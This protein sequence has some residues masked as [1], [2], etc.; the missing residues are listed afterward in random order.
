MSGGE[1]FGSNEGEI[2]NI[3]LEMNELVSSISG[4]I[5]E[6]F[7]HKL[8]IK[9]DKGRDLTIGKSEEGT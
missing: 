2:S 8:I 4:K 7:F 5:G 6:G 1:N 9:T 3:V